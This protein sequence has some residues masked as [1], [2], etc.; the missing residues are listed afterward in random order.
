M[1]FCGFDIFRFNFCNLDCLFIYLTIF[2]A[3]LCVSYRHFTA[4]ALR[5]FWNLFVFLNWSL[6]RFF[7]SSFILSIVSLRLDL[8][9]TTFFLLVCFNCSFYMSFLNILCSFLF[10]RCFRFLGN[11]L[12]TTLL[13]LVVIVFSRFRNC[14]IFKLYS[15]FDWI[16]I[17]IIL[18]VF[19]SNLFAFRIF[20]VL[21]SL[22]IF[23]YGILRCS[24]LV[25]F[26]YRRV[27]RNSWLLVAAFLCV[28]IF[29]GSSVYRSVLNRHSFILLYLGVSLVLRLTCV[30]L[31]VIL[32]I[33]FLLKITSSF[34]SFSCYGRMVRILLV[35]WN[36][37]ALPYILA[38]YVSLRVSSRLNW[39][40]WFGT[41]FLQLS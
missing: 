41:T 13:I 1:Y 26:S 18:D 32:D 30:L 16:I 4:K 6:I 40:R 12:C 24:T 14:V 10:E 2:D 5:I 29:K 17:V 31:N 7:I 36:C 22:N 38:S 28:V 34:V 33:C 25:F 8:I 23:F 20:D 39:P 21:I 9:A 27:L 3:T 15:S 37:I 11:K 35:F 19:S